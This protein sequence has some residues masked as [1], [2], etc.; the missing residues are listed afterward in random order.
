M[1]RH[2]VIQ[3]SDMHLGESKQ[4]NQAGWEACLAY[5]NKVGPDLVALTGDLVFDDMDCEE[6]HAFVRRQFDRLS[7]KWVAI[8][9]NHDIGDTNPNP[10]EGQH[11]TEERLARYKRHFGDDCWSV[12][13]GQWRL[14]G[15]NGFLPGSGFPLEDE[16]YLW[17]ESAISGA[18]GRP[19]GLFMHKPPCVDRFDEPSDPDFCMIASGRDRVLSIIGGGN[20]RFIACG[21]NHH[22]RTFTV[23]KIPMIWAPSTSQVYNMERP[24]GGLATPGLVNFWLDDSGDFEF[25]LT[26]PEGVV[27]N[28][29]NAMI[30][31]FGCMR[32][33]PEYVWDG[34]AV[35]PQNEVLKNYKNDI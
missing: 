10:Y 1:A 7:S 33:L 11:F 26:Q 18:S 6:D 22:Y 27:L 3:L 8:P 13:L 16:M 5:I 25:G 12:D 2:H 30:D 15:I 24:Y 9:G 29:T 31:H 32:N 28:N 23:D 21:H 34:R 20:I 14:I 17:L 35:P 19:I 4:Y